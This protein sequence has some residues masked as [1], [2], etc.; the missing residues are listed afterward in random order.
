MISVADM[1]DCFYLWMFLSIDVE[2]LDDNLQRTAM[3]FPFSALKT[4]Q[5]P[6]FSLQIMIMSCA[7]HVHV[8]GLYFE[9]EI[10]LIIPIFTKRIS[11]L[12][13]SFLVELQWIT[14]NLFFCI[15]IMQ[16]SPKYSVT[17][18]V[19]LLS[20]QLFGFALICAHLCMLSSR[21][22]SCRR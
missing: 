9:I 8:H 2:P 11:N 17:P 6:C 20:N 1:S 7:M 12:I 4:K 19:W 16:H 10:L 14:V 18:H 15:L 21:Y 13:T 5:W 3:L 22:D